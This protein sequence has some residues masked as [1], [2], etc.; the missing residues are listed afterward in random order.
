MSITGS[1][2]PAATSMSPMSCM[3][4]KRCTR[5]P[6]PV[7]SAARSSR[8]VSGPKLENISTP[9]TASTR[10]ISR[11]AGSGSSTAGSI[12]L[13][14]NMSTHPRASGSARASAANSAAPCGGLLFT[15]NGRGT[16]MF[17]TADHDAAAVGSAFGSIP[18][19]GFF[20][21]GELGP[22]GGQNHMH[23]FT[24]SLALFESVG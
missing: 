20:A 1:A 24:A 8:S 21:Q 9:P 13:D 5:S 18:L 12:R 10:C 14:H 4:M 22:I 3:S 17:S 23:G 6:A 15:C 16:R 11:S 19:A 2:K 7:G